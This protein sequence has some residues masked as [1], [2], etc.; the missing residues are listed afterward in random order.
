MTA[1]AD[2][3]HKL[4]SAK[5]KVRLLVGTFVSASR[6]R[7]PGRRRGGRIPAR[8]GTGYLPEVNESVEVWIFDDDTAFVMGPT[9][10]KAPSGTVTSVASGLVTLSTDFGDVVAPYVG[11]TPP[12]G[13]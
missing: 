5:R 7:L 2:L 12:P 11:D 4:I 9:V 8:F 13:R 10:T 3:L 1:E 6:T